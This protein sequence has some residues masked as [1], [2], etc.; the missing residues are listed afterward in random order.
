MKKLI[1]A[2]V[3]ASALISAPA[4]AQ[5]LPLDPALQRAQADAQVNQ[6]LN[7][8]QQANAQLNFELQ[9]QQL[10]QQQQVLSTLPPPAYQQP[11]YQPGP[12]TAPPRSLIPQ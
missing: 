7:Q 10:R 8:T 4:W 12:A 5:T 2:L 6:T 3:A 11:A 1:S 9:Q